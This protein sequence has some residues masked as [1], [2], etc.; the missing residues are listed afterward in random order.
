MSIVIISQEDLAR[1]CGYNRRLD[2]IAEVL[3]SA[4]EQVYVIAPTSGGSPIISHGSVVALRRRGA[5]G[6]ALAVF[7]ALAVIILR[8]P[9]TV[10]L[11]SIGSLYNGMLATTI[12]LLSSGR[13]VYDCQ[14]P[15]VEIL[16]ELYGQS[17][18]VRFALA[19]VSIQQR[20]LDA[21]TY[22]TLVVGKSQ[23]SLM[24]ASGWR[25]AVLP[26][27]NVHG[28]GK[29]G[30]ANRT[31]LREKLGW[32]SSKI[33]VYAGGLQRWRGI[34]VQIEAVALARKLGTD[35]RL[36]MLGFHDQEDLRLCAKGLGL[37]EDA[38]CILDAVGP[39]EL[40]DILATCDFAVS[41]ESLKY[42]MQSKIFDY[43]ANGVRIL[44]IDDG[45]DINLY[46]GDFFRYFDG[47]PHDLARHLSVLPGRMTPAEQTAAQEKLTGLRDEASANIRRA[48]GV[49]QSEH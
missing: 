44:S 25:G 3:I 47:T 18:L 10:V 24:R 35:V 20:M 33:V 23:E 2:F 19:V 17:I 9:K 4:N 6:N 41:S 12:A 1:P 39:T 49:G 46:F 36:L 45:R 32:Q 34:T 28:V 22:V 7:R 5:L 40:Y 13:I 30:N 11:T 27:L 37:S 38:V 8:R 21:A 31:K 26:V 43:L 29:Q 15:V 16:G 14:D 42:G 48:F